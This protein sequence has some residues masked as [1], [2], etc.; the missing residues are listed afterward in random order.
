MA[1]LIDR[2][3]QHAETIQIN[4]ESYRLKEAKERSEQRLK[5]RANISA[6]RK[7]TFHAQPQHVQHLESPV[8]P[9]DPVRIRIC[10]RTPAADLE[11]L[12]TTPGRS[13]RYLEYEHAIESD[14]NDFED[15]IPF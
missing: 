14:R 10:Q 15:E 13:N 4:G 3:V 8:T 6:K 2:L 12:R 9:A 11:L 1:S 5:Q 7:W